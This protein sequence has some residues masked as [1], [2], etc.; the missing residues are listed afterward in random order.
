MKLCTNK[1]NMMGMTFQ[2][3]QLYDFQCTQV[4]ETGMKAFV[5]DL[6]EIYK[7]MVLSVDCNSLEC[8]GYGVRHEGLRVVHSWI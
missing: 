1:Y 7:L 4:M 8:T 2:K 3:C 5:L 6:N